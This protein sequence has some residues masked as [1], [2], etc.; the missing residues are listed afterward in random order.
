LL[1]RELFLLAAVVVV[2]GK[3]R[4]V[5]EVLVAVL[6]EMEE[7]I[8]AAQAIHLPSVLHKEIMVAPQMAQAKDRRVVVVAQTKLDLREVLNPAPE[9]GQ[10]LRHLL[11]VV[12][13]LFQIFLEYLLP[14]QVVVEVLGKPIMLVEQGRSMP[15]PVVLVVE[16]MEQ[17]MVLTQPQEVQTQ[18]AV[19]GAVRV[20]RMGERQE[21]AALVLSFSD[22]QSLYPQ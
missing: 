17:Q 15:L 22:T 6:V 5:Q 16:A 4:E 13:D 7:I 9:E 10:E 12:M 14:T 11:K 20:F 2:I 1:H 21:Q 3:G 8:L 19:A 18:A